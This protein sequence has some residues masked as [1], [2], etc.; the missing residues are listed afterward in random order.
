MFR[1]TSPLGSAVVSVT[2]LRAGDAYNVIPDS[3]MFAGTIRSLAHDSMMRLK[4]RV[5]EMAASVAAGFGCTTDVNWRLDIQPYYPATVN[6]PAQAAFVKTVARS[7]LQDD[8]KVLEAE[9]IMGG[10]PAANF[11]FYNFFYKIYTLDDVPGL[12]PEQ[13]LYC[14][15]VA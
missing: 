10:A 11:Q 13:M 8:S 12:N 5:E 6:D 7:M 3:A 9:A 14:Y 15:P 2:M 1:E 4:G